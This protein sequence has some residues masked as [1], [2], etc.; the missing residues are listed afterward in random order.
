VDVERSH[1]SSAVSH[2]WLCEFSLVLAGFRSVTST[3]SQLTYAPYVHTGTYD[4]H[5]G[6]A[7]RLESEVKVV[8]G[9]RKSHVNSQ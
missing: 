9:W 6:E 4:A 1:I 8:A 3:S 5:S 2:R 7:Q